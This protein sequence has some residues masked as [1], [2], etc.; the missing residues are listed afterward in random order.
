MPDRLEA[1]PTPDRL[2]A[3]LTPDRLSGGLSF[4]CCM[5]E[6]SIGLC[7]SNRLLLHG[8]SANLRNPLSLSSKMLFDRQIA[9]GLFVSTGDSRNKGALLYGRFGKDTPLR[10]E[11]WDI[12]P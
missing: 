1:Y 5:L 12:D 2:E 11:G 9:A 10:L 6:C 7:E 3:Y 8:N 4:A